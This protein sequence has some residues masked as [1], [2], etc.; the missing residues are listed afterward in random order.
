MSDS[1]L[2]HVV[3]GKEKLVAFRVSVETAFAKN[4]SNF[5]TLALVRRRMKPD[6]TTPMS[7]GE[8]VGSPYGLDARTL[9]AASRVTIY[10]NGQGL[11]MGDGERLYLSLTK[12]GS[13]APLAHLTW[14]LDIQGVSR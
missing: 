1:L 13:P 14:E 2:L 5:W 12:T 3:S 7:Y 9:P 4:G 11:D 6:G 8:T 10:A